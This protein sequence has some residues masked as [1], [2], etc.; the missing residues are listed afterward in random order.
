MYHHIIGDIKAE[1]IGMILHLNLYR[2]GHSMG[3]SLDGPEEILRLYGLAG[4]PRWESE[5]KGIS[6]LGA[7]SSFVSGHLPLL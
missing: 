3:G 6:A 5:V 7:R 2:W 4:L 1:D